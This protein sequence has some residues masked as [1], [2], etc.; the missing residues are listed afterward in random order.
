MMAKKADDRIKLSNDVK[1]RVKAIQRLNRGWVKSGCWYVENR[2]EIERDGKKFLR[3]VEKPVTLR[4]Q[5][6]KTDKRKRM[7]GHMPD[8]AT[9]AI[10]IA[11][12]PGTKERIEALRKSY[13]AG[14]QPFDLDYDLEVN[15][16]TLLLGAE[17]AGGSR[18]NET[19]EGLNRCEG[20]E[21]DLGL[22]EDV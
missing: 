14:M 22:L 1:Q 17:A 6:K 4:K 7:L 10:R 2:Q 13:E 3:I 16:L 19:I 5:K 20:D 18:R 9:M 12:K 8:S 11:G 21:P 15:M